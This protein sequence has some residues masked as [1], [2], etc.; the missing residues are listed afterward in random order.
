M[1]DLSAGG[2]FNNFKAVLRQI[3]TVKIE[4]RYSKF[5]FRR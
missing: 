5:M 2:R 1:V 3:I 4:K